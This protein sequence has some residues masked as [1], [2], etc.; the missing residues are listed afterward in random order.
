MLRPIDNCGNEGDITVLKIHVDQTAPTVVATSTEQ[1]TNGSKAIDI[2]GAVYDEDAGLKA[3]RVLINGVVVIDGNLTDYII[4]NKDPS[5]I[6]A[7]LDG[8]VLYVPNKNNKTLIITAKDEDGNEVSPLNDSAVTVKFENNYGEFS[9]TGYAPANPTIDNVDITNVDKYSFSSAASY[10]KW[11]LKLTPKVGQADDW[12]GPLGDNAEIYLEAEDWA[13]H[14]GKGNIAP[15]PTKIA[16]LKI[17]TKDPKIET[18]TPGNNTSLNGTNTISGTS[19]DEGSSPEEVSIYYSKADDQ[20]NH[21]SD[22]EWLQTLSTKGQNAVNVSELYN[23]NFD[24]NFDDLIEDDKKIQNI[25]ILALVT[26][27][28]GNE[29]AISPVLYKIDRDTDRPVIKLITDG[30]NLSAMNQSQI[31]SEDKPILLKEEQVYIN[32]TDDDGN[33]QKAEFRTKTAG[34]NLGEDDGWQEIEL[35]SGSGQFVLEDDGKQTVEFRI[36]DNKGNVFTSFDETNW[37]RIYIEDAA[38]NS[39]GGDKNKKPEIY[40]LLD[41]NTPKFGDIKLST[42][43]SADPEKDEDW[44]PTNSI[45][46]IPGG[47]SKVLK[48]L[49]NA[50]DEGSGIQS[51]TA[52][53][54]I[55]DTEV[56]DY[57]PYTLSAVKGKPDYYIATID[58]CNAKIPKDGILSV[59]ILATDGA[60]R[61]NSEK[62]QYELD[63]TKPEI[64]VDSPEA[65]K[66]HSGVITAI[67]YTNELTKL[68]YT[69][70][71]S[72]EA[73]ADDA[74]SN[75]DTNTDFTTSS[76]YVYFDGATIS[77]LNHTDLVNNWLV[78]LGIATKAELESTNPNE[79]YDDI[80]PLYLHLMAQDAAGNVSK[81]A[82][83]ILVD[84]QGDRPKVE[85]SYPKK[86]ADNPDKIPVLGGAINVIGSVS[87]KAQPY[88]VYMQIDTNYDDE[89][90]ENDWDNEDKAF[91]ESDA[92][93]KY[94]LEAIPVLEDAYGIKID[95]NGDVW[96]QKINEGKEFSGRTINIRLYAV[97][98][99]GLISSPKTQ[100]IEIDDEIPKLE[101][102]IKL[103]QWDDNVTEKITVTTTGSNAGEYTI[104]NYSAIRDYTDAMSLAGKWYVV[105][106]IYDDSG[107]SEIK[108]NDT[109]FGSDASF[110]KAYE[111]TG[112]KGYVFCFPIG[113]DDENAVI[114]SEVSFSAKDGSETPKPFTKLFSV[115]CDN[116]APQV[117]PLDDNLEIMNENGFYT[118]KSQAFEQSV[119]NVNQT[120]VERVAF[121]FTRNITGQTT[122]IVDPMIRSGKAG[123]A[124]DYS[125]L[126]GDAGAFEDGLY[127]QKVALSSVENNKL[128]LSAIDD[129]IHEGG[130]AKVN[131]II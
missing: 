112:E 58:C 20:P 89:S 3:L 10:A 73:L 126:T 83:K 52:S 97:D 12:F 8:N 5:K 35:N 6:N 65:G 95:A 124:R 59:E 15:N 106:K 76:F 16:V 70:S 109:D 93:G 33:V 34:Q 87:G 22:Y 122:T 72:E 85:F 103:V 56:Q 86:D 18:L 92:G 105:G 94:T 63:N 111:K 131:G 2:S 38:G 26:D 102:E 107:I 37:K 27:M 108:Y 21:K 54:K 42:S 119:N 11:T 4:E 114:K 78:N 9:Y 130:L 23:F 40:A 41:L 36:K 48:F 29:S 84:P 32:I 88:T 46:I 30:I 77:G 50:T 68:Y 24:V 96:N 43:S 60:L 47:D 64:N 91:L 117:T 113:T 121:Y 57:S 90:D 71:D 118:F 61:T 82:Y 120:G 127:W 7:Q 125:A 51:V 39:L 74:Y 53:V 25:W 80:T 44:S 98:N 100:K 104:N 69:V 123:N 99:N 13:E 116:K 81:S 79:W 1:L 55:D 45:N 128:T 67:G 129:N 31:E 17:D 62:F 75:Y 49:V 110:I 28:A 115:T 14:E 66:E 101:Q 19:S